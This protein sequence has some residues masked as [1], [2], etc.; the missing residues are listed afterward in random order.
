M[1]KLQ[2]QISVPIFRNTVI[3]K[4]LGLAIGI[5]FGLVVIVVALASG[6]S[7]YAIYGLALIAVLF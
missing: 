1:E 3:L 5:P 7:V 6:K 2:W 4:Q